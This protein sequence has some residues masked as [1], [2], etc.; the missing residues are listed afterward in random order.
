MG[1]VTRGLVQG[2]RRPLTRAANQL[3]NPPPGESRYL[4]FAG[5]V[6]G[7]TLVVVIDLLFIIFDPKITRAIPEL[8][9]LIPV[10]VASLIGGWKASLPVALLTGA[11]YSFRFIAPTGVVQIGFTED[12]FAILTFV[13]V[14]M[15]ISEIGRRRDSRRLERERQ[16]TV[17]L[18]TVSHDLRNP[19]G[20]ILAA[21]AELRSDVVR[22]PVARNQLLDL[23]VDEANRLDRIIR[24]LLSLGRIEAGVLAPDQANESIA[25]I[26]RAS[27]ELLQRSAVAGAN[28][29]KIVIDI[30]D[31][32]DVYVDR[33]QIDQVLTNLIENAMRHAVGSST[34]LVTAERSPQPS[35]VDSVIVTVSDDGPGFNATARA[36]AFGFFKPSGATGVEGVGLAVCRAI[37]Q[38]H[39]GTISVDD[40]PDGGA[41]VAFS[42][43]AAR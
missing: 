28:P 10:T 17:L 31:G 12:T 40:Q 36:Q 8:L 41:R 15:T 24:N 3:R 27:V 30:P 7:L 39:G 32:L 20:A 21:S 23:V 5:A 43:P 14:A 25:E 29:I 16:R 18:R 42:L 34:V 13:G 26:A 22:D 1:S 33:V 37:V 6:I 19:V 2:A 9:L 38:A 35:A 11:A 4:P